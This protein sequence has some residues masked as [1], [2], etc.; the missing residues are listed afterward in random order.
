[1]MSRNPRTISAD[2]LAVE[3]AL[4]MEHNRITQ[5]LVADEA[6]ALQGALTTHDLM[7]A[8]VI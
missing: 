2:A 8:K 5:L 7:R 3:A 4:C 6:G 1:V